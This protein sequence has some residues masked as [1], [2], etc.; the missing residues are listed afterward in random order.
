MQHPRVGGVGEVE[1]AGVAIK[2]GSDHGGQAQRGP[3]YLAGQR[4]VVV[5]RGQQAGG[6]ADVA[7]FVQQLVDVRGHTARAEPVAHAVGKDDPRG[8]LRSAGKKRAK[9]AAFTAARGQGDHVA[10]QTG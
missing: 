7:E 4:E 6:V 5:E 9:V 10:L 8:A 1:L 3:R 2:R